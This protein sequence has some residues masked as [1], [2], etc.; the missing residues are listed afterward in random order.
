MRGVGRFMTRY[1]LENGA[2]LASWDPGTGAAVP[3]DFSRFSTGEA[4]WAFALLHEAFPTDGWDEPA[5]R[6]STYLATER[7]EAEGH[8]TDIPD[9]WAG[10]GLASIGDLGLTDAEIAYARQLVGYFNLRL[11][12][13]AQRT[14]EGL[15]VLVRWYPGPP[16]GYGTAGEGLGRLYDLARRE[17]RLADVVEPVR[18]RLRCAAGLFVD[19]Q[20]TAADTP[21]AADPERVAGAWFYRDYVQMDDVQHVLSALLYALPAVEEP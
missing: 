19:L 13:E 16:A 14:G 2:M 18:E 12:I 8:F 1:Q 20:A 3:G 4:F 21:A 17:P 11:T 15:N 5:R 7:D 9:H 10:Y 6:I